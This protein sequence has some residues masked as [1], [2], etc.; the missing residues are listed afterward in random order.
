M[1]VKIQNSYPSM[2]HTLNYNEEKVFLKEA[3]RIAVFNISE[4]N[5]REIRD[6]FDKYERWNIRTTEVSFQMSINPNHDAGE[7]MTDEKAI[8]LAYEIMN[9]LGYANQ[10]IAIY[11]HNDIDREHYHVVSIR[12]NEKGRKIKDTWEIKKLQKILRSLEKKYGFVIGNQEPKKVQQKQSVQTQNASISP[13]PSNNLSRQYLEA[14]DKAMKYH[15]RTFTQF[16]AIMQWYGIEVSKV[17]HQRQDIICLQGIDQQEKRCSLQLREYELGRQLLE[18]MNAR[19]LSCREDNRRYIAERKRIAEIFKRMAY[20]SFS[21]EELKH[22]LKEFNIGLL[23]S[24]NKDGHIFGLT[25]VDHDTQMAFK[26]TE[27]SKSLNIDLLNELEGNL[28]TMQAE[29][30]KITQAESMGQEV[31]R[32]STSDAHIRRT[33]YVSEEG[34]KA[35]DILSTLADMIAVG[36]PNTDSGYDGKRSLGSDGLKDK[37]KKKQK[38]QY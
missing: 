1:V 9:K 19:A 23:V 8:E 20:E 18:E 31:Q 14:F 13:V 32:D 7:K 17:E 27:I 10:P 3:E 37:K 12:T 11:R 38:S 30:E 33:H 28:R 36:G 21:L 4:N 29:Q 5:E 2:R 16:K 25:L 35:E 26:G 24:R 6:V 22:K 15:F 34:V